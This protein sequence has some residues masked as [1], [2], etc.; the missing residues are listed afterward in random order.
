[1]SN[2]MPIRETFKQAGYVS[3]K[4]LGKGEFLLTDATGK[5]ELWFSNKHHASYGIKYKNT[6]LEFARSITDDELQQLQEDRLTEELEG[7]EYR[8]HDDY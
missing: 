6:D 2:G 1:M 7:F 4:S 3:C 8:A 5:K